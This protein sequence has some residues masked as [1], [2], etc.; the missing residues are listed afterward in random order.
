MDVTF[1]ETQ[2]YYPKIDIQGEN[3]TREYQFWNLES[4]SESPITTKN[5]VPK[6]SCN[7]PEFIVDLRDKEHIKEETKEGA[8]SQQTHEAEPGS[9]PSKIPGSNAPDSDVTV[10]SELENDIL[11]I[12]IAWRKG[13]R[14][15]TQNPIGNFISYDKLSPTFHAFTSNIT[16]IQV[17][18]NIQ[19]A[20]KYPKWKVA[21]DEEVGALVKNGTWE[22]TDLPRGKKP[23]GCKW[24]FT[25]KYKADGNVDRYKARLVVKGFT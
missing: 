15:C 14:S 13:V 21:V 1:F 17:P 12:P 19:E 23:I 5:H 25:I 11:N 22:I 9:Y 2:P 24:I 20:F 10:D 8:L 18:Q 6:E 16:E 3:L 7:Q 4:F